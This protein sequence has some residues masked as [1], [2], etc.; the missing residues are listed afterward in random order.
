M[1]KIRKRHVL[2]AAVAAMLAVP[3]AGVGK[4]NGMP[5]SI[6]KG[7]GALNLIEWPAYADRKSVV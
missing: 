4:G 5:T 7:E 1:R 3:A 2:L 6:A